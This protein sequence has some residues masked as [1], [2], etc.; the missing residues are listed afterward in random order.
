MPPKKPVDPDDFWLKNDR[1]SILLSF[2]ETNPE[3]SRNLL[4]G[5]PETKQKTKSPMT[6]KEIYAKIAYRVFLNDPDPTVNSRPF[7]HTPSPHWVRVKKRLEKW[8]NWYNATQTKLNSTGAG[9][10]EEQLAQGVTSVIRASL[11]AKLDLDTYQRLNAIWCRNPAFNATTVNSLHEGPISQQANAPPLSHDN[12]PYHNMSTSHGA[13]S[14]QDARPFDFMEV[15]TFAMLRDFQMPP[16]NFFQQTGGQQQL[17]ISH[18]QEPHISSPFS[19]QQQ[20]SSALRD[21]DMPQDLPIPESFT[22]PQMHSVPQDVGASASRSDPTITASSSSSSLVHRTGNLG[23]FLNRSLS[24]LSSNSSLPYQHPG[25]RTASSP[26]VHRA[27]RRQSK[28]KSVAGLES[29]PT[30]EKFMASISKAND[31][32]TQSRAEQTKMQEDRFLR[33]MEFEEWKTMYLAQL[34][35]EKLQL[36]AE[37]E[38]L[39]NLA[40]LQRDQT[41]TL[42]AAIDFN[43]LLLQQSTSERGRDSQI[44]QNMLPVNMSILQSSPEVFASPSVPSVSSVPSV[45]STPLPSFRTMSPLVPRRFA[46]RSVSSLSSSS[47]TVPVSPL[48]SSSNMLSS[49]MSSPAIPPPAMPSPAMPH[50]ISMHR[51]AA[52]HH[53]ASALRQP[54]A[55][56]S[57]ISSATGSSMLSSTASSSASITFADFNDFNADA[58]AAFSAD[59]EMQK[60]FASV[61]PEEEEEDEDEDEDDED[62]DDEDEE[63]E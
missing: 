43:T 53:S 45:P 25:V 39:A 15:D 7:E 61:L 10:T 24:T 1:R 30:I 34:E 2:L 20:L 52:S 9:I 48:A 5:C 19:M 51:P 41:Q 40:Q 44:D 49:R 46:P 55:Y 18:E 4:W 3:D 17:N 38:R 62:E 26:S 31:E 33:M 37:T 13:T 28:N 42:K 21:F 32:A 12:E 23:A 59:P 6:K 47:R 22:V 56:Q 27:G 36:K 54:V 14:S 58:F 50:S 63:E 57:S 11:P 8:R 60:I 16:I 35:I 29:D